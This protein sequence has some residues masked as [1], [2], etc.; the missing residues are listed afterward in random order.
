VRVLRKQRIRRECKIVPVQRRLVRAAAGAQNGRRRRVRHGL[1]T[2]G[3][4]LLTAAAAISG[5]TSAA[6]I[7]ISA[8]ATVVRI[9][10]SPLSAEA[11]TLTHLADF[12]QSG[13]TS[14]A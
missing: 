10:D 13:V 12:G 2:A 14:P 8:A 9:V 4:L 7:A 3:E 6:P 5:S 11:P 1:V